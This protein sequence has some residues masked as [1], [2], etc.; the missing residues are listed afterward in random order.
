[1]HAL[2]ARDNETEV[3]ET[4]TNRYNFG[5]V[6]AL[7]LIAASTSSGE[8]STIG[9]PERFHSSALLWEICFRSAS[10]NDSRCKGSEPFTQVQTMSNLGGSLKNVWRW[11]GSLIPDE[12][13]LGNDEGS[14]RVSRASAGVND[15]GDCGPRA[16]CDDEMRGIRV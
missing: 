15:G 16:A 14:S 10:A 12:V 3:L 2:S 13:F 5:E 4:S 1:M 9:P 11:C 6:D 8:T 7:S